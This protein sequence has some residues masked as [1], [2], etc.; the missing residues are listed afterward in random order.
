MPRRLT[1][2]ILKYFHY[3][4]IIS[5]FVL[6][7]CDFERKRV[8]R[9]WGLTFYC[10][11]WA[12]F[13]VYN[14]NYASVQSYDGF[15]EIYFAEETVASTIIIE[16]AVTYLMVIAVIVI[17]MRNIGIS[18]TFYTKLLKLSNQ[19]ESFNYDLFDDAVRRQT[20]CVAIFGEV[21]VWYLFFYN[22]FGSYKNGAEKLF[23]VNPLDNSILNVTL[24]V[25]PITVVGRYSMS[26]SLFIDFT[27]KLVEKLNEKIEKTL[28]LTTNMTN[29]SLLD[30][31]VQE[32][33]LLYA[34]TLEVIR[35]FE[36]NFGWIIVILQ[37]VCMIVGINQVCIIDLCS[38]IYQ[39]LS[40]SSSCST[41]TSQ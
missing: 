21:G 25:L 20:V 24:V 11:L 12:V 37:C 6:V 17:Q 9:S 30:R 28:K 5:G 15:H 23:N 19:F 7:K 8:S 1:R 33:Q 29:A 26:I 18:M 22:L 14:F 10:C 41:C 3:S 38:S 2:W 34:Q 40:I 31:E 39:K 4:N 36:T 13:F 16:V 27:R 32:I 35:L